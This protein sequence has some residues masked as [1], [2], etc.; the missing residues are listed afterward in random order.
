[1][2][3]ETPKFRVKEYLKLYKGILKMSPVQLGL[4]VSF[5]CARNRV[6]RAWRSLPSR[7]DRSLP[8]FRVYRFCALEHQP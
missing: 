5:S 4:R 6:D 1:M 2:S 3:P 8:L 7:H